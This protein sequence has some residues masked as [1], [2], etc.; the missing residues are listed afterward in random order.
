MPG[1]LQVDIVAPFQYRKRGFLGYGNKVHH[2]ISCFLI[3]FFQSTATHPEQNEKGKQ[4]KW[5]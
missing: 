1:E 4:A 2:R 5:L 3:G